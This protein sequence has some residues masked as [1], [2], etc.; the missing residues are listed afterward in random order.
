MFEK[1]KR[2]KIKIKTN[3]EKSLSNMLISVI[4]FDLKIKESLDKATYFINVIGLIKVKLSEE[5]KG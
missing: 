2:E 1:E 5:L 4:S 3:L